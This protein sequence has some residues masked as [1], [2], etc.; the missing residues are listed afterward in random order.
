MVVVV[1]VLVD[2]GDPSANNASDKSVLLVP[3]KQTKLRQMDLQTSEW[4]LCG[5]VE[6]PWRC[7]VASFTLRNILKP[8]MCVS[9]QLQVMTLNAPR[10]SIMIKH[11]YILSFWRVSYIQHVKS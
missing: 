1:V 4:E 3:F 6:H 11:I 10:V 2:T 9:K 8:A 5:P 7:L